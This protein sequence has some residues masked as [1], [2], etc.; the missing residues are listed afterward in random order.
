MRAI[1]FNVEELLDA[2]LTR[3]KTQII[4]LSKGRPVYYVGDRVKLV[5]KQK[6]KNVCKNCLEFKTGYCKLFKTRVIDEFRCQAFNNTFGIVEITEVFKIEMGIYPKLYNRY[7]FYAMKGKDDCPYLS[8]I[9]L[10]GIYE[11]E[12]INNEGF[13]SRQEFYEWFDA[14][15][16]LKI[17]KDFY[18]YRW[19]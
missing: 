17:P 3:K 2:L 7:S 15:Y 9:F 14:K 13:A 11:S 4:R 18:V 16:D 5:W 1:S 12:I 6:A 8:D 19:K 10:P